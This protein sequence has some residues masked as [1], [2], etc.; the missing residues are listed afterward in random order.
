MNQVRKEKLQA[1]IA[2]YGTRLQI[3]QAIEELS[4]LQKVLCK[5]LKSTNPTDIT[6]ITEEMADVQVMLDQ[7]RIIFNNEDQ[8]ESNID[9]KIKRTH[10]RAGID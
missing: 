9:F 4:E 10:Q 2:Q 7:L 8:V 1:I 3:V 5:H 6:D